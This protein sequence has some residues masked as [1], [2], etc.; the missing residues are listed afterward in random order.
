MVGK[1]QFAPPMSALGEGDAPLNLSFE[2]TGPLPPTA[3]MCVPGSCHI[4]KRLSFSGC[5]IREKPVFVVRGV[6]R[7][8][9]N[10]VAITAFC[11]K[12]TFGV[13]GRISSKSVFGARLAFKS[14][15]VFGVGGR[16]RRYL[17]FVAITAFWSK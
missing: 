11:N 9:L 10:F 16:L 8:Y 14:Y 6:F 3:L 15:Y 4:Y 1:A 17:D 5:H 13:I 2:G 12:S 7:C